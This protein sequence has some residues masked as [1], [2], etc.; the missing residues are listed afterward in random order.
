MSVSHRRLHRLAVPPRSV[1]GSLSQAISDPW[2]PGCL[3]A[4]NEIARKAAWVYPG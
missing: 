3:A 4:R 1:N 2:N